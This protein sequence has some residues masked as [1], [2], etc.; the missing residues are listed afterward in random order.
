MNRYGKR[1]S[2]SDK[3]VSNSKNKVKTT[4]WRLYMSLTKLTIILPEII[5]KV[6]LHDALKR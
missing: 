6:M 5:K 1:R 3:Y 2:R 4:K